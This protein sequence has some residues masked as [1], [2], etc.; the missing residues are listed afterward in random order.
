MYCS[1]TLLQIR[2]ECVWRLKNKP[3]QDN[4]LRLGNTLSFQTH[5]E[6]SQQLATS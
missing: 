6:H 4:A 2:N 1:H 3:A 5:M